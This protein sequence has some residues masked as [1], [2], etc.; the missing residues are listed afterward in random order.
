MADSVIA[1]TRPYGTWPVQ[2]D[3]PA[4]THI[5]DSFKINPDGST[6]LERG[7]NA[8]RAVVALAVASS[9]WNPQYRED[10]LEQSLIS[11]IRFLGMRDG[12]V[13]PMLHSINLAYAFLPT[14]EAEAHAS[15][16]FSA[17]KTL[18]LE[19]RMSCRSISLK[20]LRYHPVC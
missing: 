6:D 19:I 14:K 3:D 12:A 18:D 4:L 2:L 16:V 11:G 10:K 15:V 20:I 8:Y 1:D 17:F 7:Q 5:L 9:S 13:E